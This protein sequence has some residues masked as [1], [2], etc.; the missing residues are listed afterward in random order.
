M[1]NHSLLSPRTQND[2]GDKN[3]YLFIRGTIKEFTIWCY[4]NV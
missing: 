2:K 4:Q 1:P 3:E